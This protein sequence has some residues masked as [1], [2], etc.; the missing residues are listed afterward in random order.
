MTQ[1]NTRIR[2]S[3]IRGTTASV[4]RKHADGFYYG[5]GIIRGVALGTTGGT[6][7]ERVWTVVLVFLYGA[8]VVFGDWGHHRIVL[9]NLALLLFTTAGIALAAGYWS[10]IRRVPAP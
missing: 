1:T 9:T 2:G 5:A 6:L 7:R 8:V 10:R 4:S 3:A